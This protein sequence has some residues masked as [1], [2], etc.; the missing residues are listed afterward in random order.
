MKK[1]GF[2]EGMAVYD[3]HRDMPA[4]IESIDGYMVCLVRPGGQP[5]EAPKGKLRL[6][7]ADERRQ[8]RALALRHERECRRVT[9]P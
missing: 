4:V 9:A 7:S 3:T 5:W 6:A 2:R 8:L 1:C